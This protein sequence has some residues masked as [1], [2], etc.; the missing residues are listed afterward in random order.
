MSQNTERMPLRH[1]LDLIGKPE[2]VCKKI[3]VS[4]KTVWKWQKIGF[5]DKEWAAKTNYSGTIAALCRNNGY[6]VTDDEVL[7]SGG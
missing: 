3:G 4:R 6:K 5:P 7:N 2:V 1:Y